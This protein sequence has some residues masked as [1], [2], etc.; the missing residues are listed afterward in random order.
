MLRE[1]AYLGI[2]AYSIFKSRM[3]GVDRWLERLGRVVI[4]TSADELA[5]R[6][7][8]GRRTGPF[9]R[10]DANPHL[11]DDIVRVVWAGSRRELPVGVSH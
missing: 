11:I 10:L 4:I 9:E 2:P 1:A 7:L 3:G 5:R 6:M 8:P